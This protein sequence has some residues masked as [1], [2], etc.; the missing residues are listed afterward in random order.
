MNDDEWKK[1]IG[2]ALTYGE[3]IHRLKPNSR[4][5]RREEKEGCARDTGGKPQKCL[6]ASFQLSPLSLRLPRFKA[7]DLFIG[8]RNHSRVVAA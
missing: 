1:Y 8:E 2:H 4:L 6:V 7:V 3:T 5:S